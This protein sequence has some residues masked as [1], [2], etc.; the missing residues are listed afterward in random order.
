MIESKCIVVSGKVQGVWFRKTT[1]ERAD[2]LGLKGMVKN[3]PNGNV[4]I[5]VQGHA[6]AIAAFISFCWKGPAL[7]RVE[8]VKIEELKTQDYSGFRIA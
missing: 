2:A 3:L 6:E 7:A 8:A 4:Y 5:E 1:K